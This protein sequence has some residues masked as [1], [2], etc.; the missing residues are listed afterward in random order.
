VFCESSCDPKQS[1]MRF[2]SENRTGRGSGK[3]LFLRG[4]RP[5][6]NRGFPKSEIAK[7][8]RGVTKGITKH[9]A[10]SGVFCYRKQTALLSCLL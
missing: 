3:H 1:P 9:T 8:L 10:K 4:G 5:L 2:A 7:R 6:E